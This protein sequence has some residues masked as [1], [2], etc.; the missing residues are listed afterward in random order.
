REVDAQ[1][2]VLLDPIVLDRHALD[3][4]R[5]NTVLPPGHSH[6]AVAHAQVA[7]VGDVNGLSVLEPPARIAVR[8]AHALDRDVL[9]GAHLDDARAP[10]ELA[11]QDRV[12]GR[13]DAAPVG[14]Q[15]L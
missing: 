15:V 4:L 9:A 14:A 5:A 6:D 13:G 8:H 7:G 11:P 3:I 1:R 12:I 10:A 2:P